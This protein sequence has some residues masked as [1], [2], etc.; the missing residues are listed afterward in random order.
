MLH[1]APT[2][3]YTQPVLGQYI[4]KENICAR[5]SKNN[6]PVIVLYLDASCGIISLLSGGILFV[7]PPL[8]ALHL[9]TENYSIPA[10]SGVMI[11]L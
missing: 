7:P 1:H 3:E 8:L 10:T 6:W 9:P 2:Q 5:Y 11:Y 4:F